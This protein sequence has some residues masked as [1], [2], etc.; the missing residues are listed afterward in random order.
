M[1]MS[2]YAFIGAVCGSIFQIVLCVGVISGCVSLCC[3]CHKRCRRRRR[4]QNGVNVIYVPAPV[5]PEGFHPSL[6]NYYPPVSPPNIGLPIPTAPPP[7]YQEATSTGPFSPDVSQRPP[8]YPTHPP[9]DQISQQPY[10]PEYSLPK[11][12]HR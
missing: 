2:D 5:P 6:P 8:M 12:D 3:W 10:N 7:S 1:T 9:L 4:P 11:Y